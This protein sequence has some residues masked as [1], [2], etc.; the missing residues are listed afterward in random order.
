MATHEQVGII[1]PWLY[2]CSTMYFSLRLAAISFHSMGI[3]KYMRNLFLFN[4]VQIG[5]TSF[6]LLQVGLRRNCNV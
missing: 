5:H 3:D 6:N 2:H 4:L 1:G